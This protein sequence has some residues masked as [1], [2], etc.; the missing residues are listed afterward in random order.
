MLER[1]YQWVVSLELEKDEWKLIKTVLL[2][3]LILGIIL[4]VVDNQAVG[5]SLLR[6][7]YG[8]GEKKEMLMVTLG[9]GQEKEC[10][11]ILISEQKYGRDQIELLQEEVW[12]IIRTDISNGHESLQNVQGGISMPQIVQG[13]PFNIKWS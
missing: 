1:V 7:T 8:E 10:I 4:I 13:Y 11:E 5:D 3:S 2:G 6:S 12:E 9:E